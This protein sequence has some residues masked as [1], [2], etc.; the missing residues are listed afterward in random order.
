MQLR[1]AGLACCDAP[2]GAGRR[3]R[4]SAA[5]RSRPGWGPGA[6]RAHGR[7]SRCSKSLRQEQSG[8]SRQ[9]RGSGRGSGGGGRGALRDG[10]ACNVASLCTCLGAR[11]ARR[12]LQP[13]DREHCCQPHQAKPRPRRPPRP[14][15]GIARACRGR[16][17]A[18]VNPTCR[19]AG[20]AP[21]L[22]LEQRHRGLADQ[23]LHRDV[24]VT[25][26]T[27]PGGPR[28]LAAPRGA[29]QRGGVA[30]SRG[31]AVPWPACG[32]SVQTS[33]SH[34]HKAISSWHECM[35]PTA[36]PCLGRSPLRRTSPAHAAPDCRSVRRRPL[37]SGCWRRSTNSS[38]GQVLYC[39][40]SARSCSVNT[41]TGWEASPTSADR[42]AQRRQHQEA[43][44]A[45]PV[46]LSRV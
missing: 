12:R 43:A 46:L 4:A 34:A 44:R 22:L 16:G 32:F 28:S 19:A 35:L 18:H 42:S 5:P 33:F 17:H 2:V 45:I 39:R 3:L 15:F 23:T 30:T 36:I 1:Q 40:T 31:T 9:A 13:S 8:G 29:P 27:G 6:P 24:L 20:E 38:M 11:Q 41:R 7:T 10:G 26:A 14:C 25:I 37:P 21:R